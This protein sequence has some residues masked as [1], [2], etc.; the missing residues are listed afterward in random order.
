MILTKQLRTEIRS[1]REPAVLVDGKMV[2]GSVPFLR[3][4]FATVVDPQ[5]RDDL[6][7]ELAGEYLRAD[8]EDEHLLVQRERVANHPDAAVMWLGL[9][10]SLSMRSDGAAEARQAVAKGL[11]ISRRQGTLIRFALVCQA[12]VARRLNDPTLFAQALAE[13]IADAPNQREDDCGLNEQL[14][15]D[16]PEGFCAS[17]LER[18]YRQ[19]LAG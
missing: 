4:L 11:E 14:V 6:L 18:Q 12:D 19:C 8:L 2:P 5:D 17:E 9:A 15:D 7:G 1:R 13:L 3:E 16:L 10:Q